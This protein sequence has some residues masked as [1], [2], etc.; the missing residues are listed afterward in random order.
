MKNAALA[1]LEAHALRFAKDGNNRKTFTASGHEWT[2]EEIK[3]EIT[4]ETD[5]GCKF[6]RLWAR[7]ESEILNEIRKAQSFSS[8]AR[9]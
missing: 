4:A 2:I 7:A 8:K 5:R 9:L 1:N 3:A 6:A